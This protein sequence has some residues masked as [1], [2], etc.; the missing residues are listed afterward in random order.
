M[1][2]I[3]RSVLFCCH[4]LSRQYYRNLSDNTLAN[5]LQNHKDEFTVVL[6]HEP[7]Y[8][9]NYSGEKV[10]LVMSGHAHAELYDSDNHKDFHTP[11]GWYSTVIPAGQYAVVCG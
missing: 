4:P 5:I 1:L 11:A 3:F 10:D 2:S 9:S 7:Q 8:F 6:A